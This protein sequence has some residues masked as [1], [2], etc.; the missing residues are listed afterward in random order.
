MTTTPPSAVVFDLGGVLVDWD[1]RYLYRKLIAD[2]AAMEAFLSEVCTQAWNQE[3]DRGR[4]VSEATRELLERH[5]EHREL[6]EA[7]YGRWDE[8]MA[9]AMPDAEALFAD[10]RATDLGVFALSNWSAETFPLAEA[11]FDFLGHF[12]GRVISGQDGVIKPDPAIFALALERFGLEPN[13]AIFLDDVA[14]N[15]EAANA[16]GFIGIHFES[17]TQAREALVAAGVPIA[18]AP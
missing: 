9:G 5:P 14:V 12:D 16:N 10:V 4:P 1:P 17:T 18:R 7:F 15:V 6:I 3:Q 11:R 8:M 13:T 2:E